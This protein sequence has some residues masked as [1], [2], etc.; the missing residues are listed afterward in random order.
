[1]FDHPENTNH[2]TK[3]FTRPGFFGAAAAMDHD[4]VIEKI[5]TLTLKYAFLV[6]EE[7]PS[8]EW[9]NQQYEEYVS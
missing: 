5:S 8:D 1:M 7:N 9:L 2:P 3:W 4:L 6:L